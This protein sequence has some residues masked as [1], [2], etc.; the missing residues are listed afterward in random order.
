[1]KSVKM[2]VSVEV[3]CID[4]QVHNASR[5]RDVSTTSNGEEKMGDKVLVVL[6]RLNPVIK[7]AKI[8]IFGTQ[9]N[10]RQEYFQEL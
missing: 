4:N 10:S 6:S 3:D 9:K 1:M 7:I 2:I 8:P 5:R